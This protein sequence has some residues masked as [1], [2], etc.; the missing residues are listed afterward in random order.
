MDEYL[1]ALVRVLR[2]V[3]TQSARIGAA[4]RDR[5]LLE[6][7]R[8]LTFGAATTAATATATG[9]DSGR[10]RGVLLDESSSSEETLSIAKNLFGGG[11]SAERAS[12]SRGTSRSRTAAAAEKEEEEEGSPL[13]SAEARKKHFAH[14]DTL[15]RIAGAKRPEQVI[16]NAAACDVAGNRRAISVIDKVASL[17]G[18]W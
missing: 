11:D 7:R 17:H 10:D 16:E 9:N 8:R 14:A 3:H 2:F 1:E 13:G 4:K 15:S 5:V 18:G 12:S 6:R